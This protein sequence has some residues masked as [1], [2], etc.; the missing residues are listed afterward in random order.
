MSHRD[1]TPYPI[2]FFARAEA[3]RPNTGGI[4]CNPVSGDRMQKI[5]TKI[6]PDN[7]PKG[8]WWEDD[9]SCWRAIVDEHC[10]EQGWR[11]QPA[12][13]KAFAKETPEGEMTDFVPLPS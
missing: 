10:G 5:E 4:P 1:R 11:W 7:L 2:I 9:G 12:N 3:H 8:L 6:T 13:P